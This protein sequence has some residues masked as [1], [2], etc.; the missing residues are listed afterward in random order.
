MIT[1]LLARQVCL[2]VTGRKK[3]D[4]RCLGLQSIQKVQQRYIMYAMCL[5]PRGR[6][7]VGLKHEIMNSRVHHAKLPTRGSGSYFSGL[8]MLCSNDSPRKSSN[9]FAAP[10]SQ[11]QLL[12]IVGHAA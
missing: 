3:I 9:R 1:L 11:Q 6:L 12:E 2:V 7:S 10:T 8:V 5:L 4:L